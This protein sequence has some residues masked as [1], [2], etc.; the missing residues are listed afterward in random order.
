MCICHVVVARIGSVSD[1]DFSMKDVRADKSNGG[2]YVHEYCRRFFIKCLV[3]RRA[4]GN[5]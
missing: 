5:S 1:G 4:L 2:G 3:P